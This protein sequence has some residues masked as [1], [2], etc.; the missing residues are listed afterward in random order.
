CREGGA[1]QRHPD[2]APTGRHDDLAGSRRAQA[3]AIRG[4]LADVTGI[5]ELRGEKPGGGEARFKWNQRR[6]A[7]DENAIEVAVDGGDDFGVAL[8]VVADDQYVAHR[9]DD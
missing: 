4:R 3:G 9:G 1:E 6:I 5:A 8:R 2:G 7:V